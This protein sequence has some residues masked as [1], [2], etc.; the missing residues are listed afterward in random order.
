M[1]SPTVITVYVLQ[2]SRTGAWY[3]GITKDLANRLDEHN[4]GESR[5]TSPGRPWGLIYQEI[6]PDYGEARRREKYLKSTRGRNWLKNR[7]GLL[8]P[9]RP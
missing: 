3:V 5:A 1:D 8:D 4:H 2:S 6:Q 7:L 9:H